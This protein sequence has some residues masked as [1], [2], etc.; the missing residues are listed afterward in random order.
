M[1]LFNFQP[2]TSKKSDKELLKKSSLPVVPKAANLKLKSGNLADTI[3]NIRL[4]TEKQFKNKK[5]KLCSITSEQQL[6]ELIDLAIKNKVLS[7]DT[8]TTSLD[9]ITTTLAGVC[10]YTPA[11]VPS[12]IPINHVNFV[13]GVRLSGQLTEDFVKQQLER[14]VDSNPA[15]TIMFNSDFDVRV[16]HFTLG[17]DITCTWDCYTAARL[18]DENN[19]V[20]RLKALWDRYVN[21]TEQ[22]S[23]TFEELF[24]GV[25]FTMIP[26]DIAY[27]YAANDPLI[28]Y[29]LYEFQ[30]PFLTPENSVCQDYDLVNVAWVFRNIEMK[31][32]PIVAQMENTGVA[33]D[34]EYQ[35][36]LSK[37]Y[38]EKLVDIENQFYRE[39]ENWQEQITEYR[40]SQGSSCKLSAKVNINSPTQIAILLYD[41]MKLEPV[42]KK[43][44]RGTGEDIL[45][46]LSAQSPICKIILEQR[47]IKKL[48]S[49]YIDKFSDVINPVT[50]R[51]HCKFNPLGTVTGRFSSNS[52][53]LQ[54]I[55]SH[56]KDIRKMFVA[57]AGCYLISSD[58]SAQEPRLTVHLAKDKVGIKA[59]QDGKD[60]Y[61]EI[62]SL[63]FNKPYEDCLEFRPDGAHN[64]EGKERRGKAKAIFL[65][66]CYGKGIPAIAEDLHITDK[67]AQEV[68]NAVLNAFPGLKQFME[69][70]QHM[71]EE[72]GFVTTVWGRK[73][74]LPDM[75]LPKYEFE[76]LNGVSNDFDP[77]ADEDENSEVPEEIVNYYWNKLEKCKGF[78]QK[79]KIIEEAKEENI[80]IIDNNRK[81][82]DATRQC[83]NSRVQ[84]SAADLTKLAMIK[85]GNNEELKQL[86]FKLLIPVHDEIIGEFPKENAKRVVQLVEYCMVHAAELSVPLKCD[87][88]ITEQWYGEEIKI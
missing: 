59:Y 45:E 30:Y 15:E 63:A 76:W 32:L 42:S 53:N 35:K 86:G 34:L 72:Q 46:Q 28:T 57:S 24:S 23:A 48:I 44:P 7:I 51:V 20:N 79:M 36:K 74:R 66:I 11:S 9:P 14:Y 84:G 4:I 17:L 73:R 29:E 47:G 10:L 83:V 80:K 82:A 68:Y 58:Y 18:L 87:T 62:A 55:P 49:T 40:Y 26:I 52:P 64:A 12:Y 56:N 39:L 70:S 85:M 2:K 65:G 75:R 60:L 67:H 6:I 88:E 25:P 5:D 16:L 78:K 41:V 71:A 69:D 77:L 37:I 1:G 33:V 27:L 13:T 43:T 38:N 50:G 54:N 22:T 8:E 3:K 21:K 19:K 61:A 81:I 31:I